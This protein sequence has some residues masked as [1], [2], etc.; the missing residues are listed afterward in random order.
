[1]AEFGINFIS[2]CLDDKRRI[3]TLHVIDDHNRK[4]P[5]IFV[6]FSL[7]S[8]KLIEALEHVIDPYGKPASPRTDN[9]PEF[10]SNTHVISKTGQCLR[11]HTVVN[12][13]GY[14]CFV[15]SDEAKI[16]LL[17]LSNRYYTSNARCFNTT[18]ALVGAASRLPKYPL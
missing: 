14:T 8:I 3:R 1:M 13:D 6:D 12:A 5:G 11:N 16:G 2:D 7:P 4:C 10:T 17:H 18:R 9:G 15:Q